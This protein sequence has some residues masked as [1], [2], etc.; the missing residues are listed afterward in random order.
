MIYKILCGADF[1]WGA[2]DPDKQKEE[3]RFIYEYLEKKPIDLLVICGDYFDHRLL[4]NSKS[5]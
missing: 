3:L 5:L 1:H 2:M 4:L